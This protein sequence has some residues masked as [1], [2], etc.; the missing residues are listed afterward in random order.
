MAT[1]AKETLI[2]KLTHRIKEQLVVNGITEFTITD[3]NFHFA[4]TDEKARANVII[5]DYLTNMLDNHAEPLV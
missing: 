2:S 5:R 1:E 4:N 3:G